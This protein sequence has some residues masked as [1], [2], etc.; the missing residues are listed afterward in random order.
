M[1]P[2]A[3]KRL[4]LD[5]PSNLSAYLTKQKVKMLVFDLGF[6]AGIK[7]DLKKDRKSTEWSIVR[8][9]HE[10]DVPVG[11]GFSLSFL[12]RLLVHDNWKKLQ[13]FAAGELDK[14]R[15]TLVASGIEPM[16]S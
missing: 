7:N 11:I 6:E 16:G 15:T 1:K 4:K 2:L 9:P 8:Y 12:P 13:H 3:S 5:A 10:A 14:F